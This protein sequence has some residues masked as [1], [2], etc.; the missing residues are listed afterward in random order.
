MLK[1]C[2]HI[3]TAYSVLGKFS[4]GPFYYYAEICTCGTLIAFRIARRLG[5]KPLAA[6]VSLLPK[7]RRYWSVR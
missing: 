4:D 2:G 1:K 6:S 3:Q 7:E 5:D